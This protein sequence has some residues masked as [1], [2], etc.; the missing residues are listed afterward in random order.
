MSTPR[1]KSI[2]T[3]T[4]LLIVL[5][6]VS[7]AS[8]LTTQLRIGMP[9]R[10]PGALTGNNGSNFQGNNNGGNSQRNNNTGGNFQGGNGNFQ[11]R[12]GTAGFNLFSIYRTVGINGLAIGYL[13]LGFAG[14]SIMLVLVS[15][16]GVWKQKRWGLNLAVVMAIIFLIGAVPS[17][18]SLGGRFINWSRF[19]T[20]VLS[21]AASLTILFLG[22]LPSVR[23]S[24][25]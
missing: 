4:V 10:Q 3:I 21:V 19:V 23:D 22:I 15:A 5:A 16:F 6:L 25:K 14:L 20:D 7:L 1:T 13:G 9:A 12:T 8:N 11:R 24:V 17:L 2:V 18:F